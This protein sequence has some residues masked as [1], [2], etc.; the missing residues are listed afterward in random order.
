[1]HICIY[2]TTQIKTLLQLE[3]QWTTINVTQA[4][5][6]EVH[7]N[8]QVL[9]KANVTHIDFVLCSMQSTEQLAY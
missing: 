7:P 6:K 9:R 2:V 3:E 1:M 5:S 4:K 8:S